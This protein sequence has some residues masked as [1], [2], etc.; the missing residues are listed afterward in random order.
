MN[1]MTPDLIY[2]ID[3]ENDIQV[4]VKK[5]QSVSA[6]QTIDWK[7]ASI[8]ATAVLGAVTG[9]FGAAVA[10]T[11]IG[12]A[13]AASPLIARLFDKDS[14]KKPE[15]VQAALTKLGEYWKRHSLTLDQARKDFEFP[16]GHPVSGGEYRRHPLAN[17]KGPAGRVIYIPAD[18]YDEILLEERE[19]ELLMLLIDLGATRISITKQNSSSAARAFSANAGGGS[20][21]HG[22]AH[23]EAHR[24]TQ[25]AEQLGNT[26][27]FELQGRDLTKDDRDNFDQ[28]RFSWVKFEPSWEVLIRARI[29]G[30]CTKAALEVRERST[31]SDDRGASAAIKAKMASLDISAK[32]TKENEQEKIY[33]VQADFKSM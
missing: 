32:V 28:S 17:K 13:A 22:E 26:R 18:Q 6:D 2:I 19:A 7:K 15:E 24:M 25:S 3:H 33:L 30:F 9:P 12:A 11:L 21:V 29:V 5:I 20:V 10:P 8:V 1:S 4:D 23:V 14:E 27:V 16:P 31:Y